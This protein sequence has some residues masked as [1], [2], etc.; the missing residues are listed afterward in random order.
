MISVCGLICLTLRMN[1]SVL[2]D[3]GLGIGRVAHHER[4]LRARCRSARIFSAMASVFSVEA[5]PP[6]FMRCSVSSE[7]DSAPMKTIRRPLSRISSQVRSEY[8]SSVSMRDSPH[9]PMFRSR[10]RSAK[11]AVRA[12]WTKKLLS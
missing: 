10:I 11:S 2:C 5:V 4:E 9:Q 3:V 12:S 6:L 1:S 7:P 8:L